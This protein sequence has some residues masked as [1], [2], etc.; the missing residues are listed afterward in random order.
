MTKPV[1]EAL[2]S[3]RLKELLNYSPDTGVFTWTADVST[4]AHKGKVAGHLSSMGYVKIRVDGKLE[5]AHRLAVLYMQGSLPEEDVDHINGTRSDN[6]WT[7]LRQCSRAENCQNMGRVRSNTSGVTGVHY[8]K[9]TCKWMAY[10]G[11]G[12]KLHHLGR[13]STLGEAL[14][15]REKAKAEFHTF[16][17]EQLAR[18]A[19]QG[20]AA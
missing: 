1:K 3:A 10:I 5:S 8:D 19:F 20:A 9:A 17:P 4:K 2:S 15:A 13:F 14:A 7:N 18:P 11:S 6:R 16:Q 12:L